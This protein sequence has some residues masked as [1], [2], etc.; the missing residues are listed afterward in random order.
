MQ[1]VG[2]VT[3]VSLAAPGV[4]GGGAVGPVEGVVQGA[5]GWRSYRGLS[6]CTRCY[7]KMSSRAS[8]RSCAGGRRLEE[9]Q[10]SLL[11]HQQYSRPLVEV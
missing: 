9:L 2:G 11:L 10:R 7:R 5:G 6:C 1:E 3:E 8:R 4:T